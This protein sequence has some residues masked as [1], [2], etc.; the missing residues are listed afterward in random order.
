MRLNVV[1]YPSETTKKNIYFTRLIYKTLKNS[2]DHTKLSNWKCA[3]FTRRKS[4]IESVLPFSFAKIICSTRKETKLKQTKQVIKHN[5]LTKSLK[6]RISKQ[7]KAR[8][9]VT[10]EATKYKICVWKTKWEFSNPVP[11]FRESAEQERCAWWLWT[12]FE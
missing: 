8:N 9:G 4:R 11:T 7:Y 12:K 10:K 1:N 3:N 6:L 2:R 5:Q